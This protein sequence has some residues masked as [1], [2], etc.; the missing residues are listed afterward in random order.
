MHRDCSYLSWLN[1][2]EMISCWIALDDTTEDGGTMELV[3]GSHQWSPTD[4]LGE[5]HDPT[6][7]QALMRASALV[8]GIERPEIVPPVPVVQITA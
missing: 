1:P 4:K 3:T 6:D 5:F 2:R 7:Y 8:E